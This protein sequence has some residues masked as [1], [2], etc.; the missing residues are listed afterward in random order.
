MRVVSFFICLH[1]T[2]MTESSVCFVL[3]QGSKCSV[4][5][6]RV[7][8]TGSNF[9]K[10]F[11]EASLADGDAL[12]YSLRSEQQLVATTVMEYLST[13]PQDVKVPAEPIAST[14]SDHVLPPAVAK[15]LNQVLYE[16]FSGN[17]AKFKNVALLA[18]RLQF[19]E[20]VDWI[21]VRIAMMIHAL[22][23]DASKVDRLLAGLDAAP[24]EP[25]SV[26]SP[27]DE[28]TIGV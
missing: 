12:T 20:L 17:V 7:L 4:P 27:L 14:R 11:I 1:T 5:V 13:P 21:L 28:F 26:Q 22:R 6:T 8:A 18:E 25:C 10:T 19:Y 3:P 2:I 9:F 16:R 23:L 15:W 24:S